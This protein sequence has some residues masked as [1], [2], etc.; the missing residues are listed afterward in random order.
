MLVVLVAVQ[1]CLWAFA[2]EAVQSVASHAAVIA[3]GLGGTPSSGATAGQ[4]AAAQIA[5][6]VLLRPSVVVTSVAGGQVL[7]TVQGAVES[8]LPWWHPK[9]T[10]V[11]TAVVQRFRAGP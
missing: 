9:V 4:V 2:D 1:L 5:G 11:R 8:I 10:A 3:A 6:P 7:V